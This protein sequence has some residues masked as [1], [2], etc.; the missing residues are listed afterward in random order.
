MLVYLATGA[1][2]TVLY[3]RAAALPVDLGDPLEVAAIRGRVLVFLPFVA[4]VGTLPR[5]VGCAVR[6]EIGYAPA[7]AARLVVPGR[8]A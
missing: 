8:A 2:P 6:A 7:G 5:P 3:P 4:H 1:G